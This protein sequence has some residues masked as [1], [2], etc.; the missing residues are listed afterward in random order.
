M[1]STI[2][3]PCLSQAGL[4]RLS[5]DCSQNLHHPGT[6]GGGADPV[7][8]F[9]GSQVLVQSARL[10]FALLDPQRLRKLRVIAAIS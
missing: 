3:L 1:L 8:R 2:D 9:T 4:R 6:R 10:E 7:V 5:A